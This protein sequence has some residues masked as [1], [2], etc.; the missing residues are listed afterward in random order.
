M[1]GQYQWPEFN[2]DGLV[3]REELLSNSKYSSVPSNVKIDFSE[4]RVYRRVK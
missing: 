2:Y 4:V 3:T 1:E